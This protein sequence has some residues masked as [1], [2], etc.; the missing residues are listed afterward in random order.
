MGEAAIEQR[1]P[2]L[3]FTPFPGENQG[4]ATTRA[5]LNRRPNGPIIFFIHL[6]LEPLMET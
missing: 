6:H 1:C 4:G 5:K 2:S 3:R